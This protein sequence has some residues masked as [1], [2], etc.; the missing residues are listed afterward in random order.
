MSGMN[1]SKKEPRH[2]PTFFLSS[3]PPL[4]VYESQEDDADDVDDG[5]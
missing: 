1:G 2:I 5:E 4:V 3:S